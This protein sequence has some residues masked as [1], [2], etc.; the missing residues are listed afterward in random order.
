MEN[1]N[2]GV[3]QEGN[4]GGSGGAGVDTRSEA[5]NHHYRHGGGYSDRQV[6]ITSPSAAAAGATATAQPQKSSA[7]A[8]SKLSA[9]LNANGDGS[10]KCQFC[11]KVFPRLGYLKKHEQVSEWWRKMMWNVY[12]IRRMHAHILEYCDKMFTYS[13]YHWGISMWENSENIPCLPKWVWVP[14]ISDDIL[15]RRVEN[16]LLISPLKYLLFNR[17]IE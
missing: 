10:Y 8:K 13:G 11:K 2:S 17:I 3:R 1:S 4:N 12:V 15:N 14:Y 7:S 5:N 16:G 9:R 6:R